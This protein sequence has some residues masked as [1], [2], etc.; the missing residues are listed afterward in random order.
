MKNGSIILCHN[1]SDHI[2]ESLPLIID[3]LKTEG[4]QMV[5][6]SDLV[7]EDNY[8]IDNNGLQKLK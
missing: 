2:V 8:Y 5:K 1:N 3:Y 4:Y 7:Y 6:I